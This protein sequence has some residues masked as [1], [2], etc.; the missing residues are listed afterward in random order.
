MNKNEKKLA[1]KIIA[2]FNAS[3]KK[4]GDFTREE[5]LILE[6][7]RSLGILNED[8]FFDMTSINSEHKQYLQGR[9]YP[10]TLLGDDEVKKNWYLHFR[11]SKGIIIVRDVFTIISFLVSLYVTISKFIQK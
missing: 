1:K 6:H 5:N 4:D 11:D 7:W 2:F 3:S 8:A 9:D 10:F